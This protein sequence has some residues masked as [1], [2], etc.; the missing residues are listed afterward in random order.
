MTST[1]ATQGIATYTV[2][3]WSQAKHGSASGR[4]ALRS[5][6]LTY[7]MAFVLVRAWE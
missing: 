6:L 2:H 5:Q 4:E 1:T 3:R 7:V